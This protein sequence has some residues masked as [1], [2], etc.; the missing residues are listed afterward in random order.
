MVPAAMASAT[1]MWETMQSANSSLRGG[2][3][4]GTVGH[5]QS[6]HLCLGAHPQQ[7]L[8]RLRPAH[9]AQLMVAVQHDAAGFLLPS[10]THCSGV[11][12]ASFSQSQKRTL[13]GRVPPL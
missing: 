11:A 9:G 1:V 13:P 7:L 4:G 12:A 3:D 10:R 5:T 8:H 6:Q 2:A